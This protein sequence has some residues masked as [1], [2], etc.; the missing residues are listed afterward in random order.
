V[1]AWVAEDVEVWAF[2]IPTD[3]RVAAVE[4]S[5]S[6]MAPEEVGRVL[7][8]AGAVWLTPPLR[9]GKAM[10]VATLLV[11]L[12]DRSLI[13]S[14]ASWP[15]PAWPASPPLLRAGGVPRTEAG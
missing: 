7:A 2:L 5:L 12:R 8:A 11:D 15:R 13:G 10:T 1:S 6:G 9:I 3:P 4:R 14:G